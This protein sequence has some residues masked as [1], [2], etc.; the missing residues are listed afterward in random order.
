MHIGNRQVRVSTLLFL[1]V[2]QVKEDIEKE[3]TTNYMAM[4][5]QI[6]TENLAKIAGSLNSN[7]E[8][9][10]MSKT[11]DEVLNPKPQDDRTAEEIISDVVRKSGIKVV[12]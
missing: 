8:P 2:E 6:I 12:K 9:A 4:C 1:I 5:S 7:L 10:Y 11:L 3:A